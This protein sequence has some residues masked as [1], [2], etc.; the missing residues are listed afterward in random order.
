MFRATL[1]FGPT[2]V[3]LEATLCEGEVVLTGEPNVG[4]C[5]T[6]E[7]AR[8]TAQRLLEAVRAAELRGG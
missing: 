7:A 2:T 8:A 1:G 3:P 4:V 6:I 5:L